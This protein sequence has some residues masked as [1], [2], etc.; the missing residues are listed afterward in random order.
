VT[1]IPKYEHFDAAVFAA[2][3]GICKAGHDHRV[4]TG[5]FVQGE[6]TL[7]DYFA[8]RALQGFMADPLSYESA[9]DAAKSAYQIADAMLAARGEP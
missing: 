9:A 8:G 6:M 2:A 7:R 1:G 5:G 3:S 4:A